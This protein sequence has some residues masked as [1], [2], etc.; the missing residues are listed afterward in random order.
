MSTVRVVV[1]VPK[2][3]AFRCIGVVV[4]GCFRLLCVR[5]DIVTAHRLVSTV[6]NVPAPF[7]DKCAFGCACLITGSRIDGSGPHSRPLHNLDRALSWVRHKPAKSVKRCRG[8]VDHGH[9]H[10]PEAR[11]KG[12]VEVVDCLG[13]RHSLHEPNLPTADGG[14]NFHNRKRTLKKFTRR[15]NAS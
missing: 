9:R 12:R 8:R 13:H 14:F 7:A 10:T 4:A 5:K 1:R 6:E 11:R 15:L 3:H 2:Q